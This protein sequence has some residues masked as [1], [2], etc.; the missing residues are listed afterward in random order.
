MSYIS[1]T[2][3]LEKYG[4][5]YRHHFEPANKYLRAYG[6]VARPTFW[7]MLFGKTPR[8]IQLQ[9]EHVL[10]DVVNRYG[11]ASIE[12]REHGWVPLHV[13]EPHF[14]PP[15][16]LKLGMEF[17]PG[18][19]LPIETPRKTGPKIPLK[20]GI[21]YGRA[22]LSQNLKKVRKAPSYKVPVKHKLKEDYSEYFG[23]NAIV[24]KRIRNYEAE[25]NPY[26]LKP[27]QAN[28]RVFAKLT[29]HF[30]TR[31]DIPGLEFLN[32][33]E[34]PEF[35][36]KDYIPSLP[37]YTRTGYPVPIN[38]MIAL[39]T[40]Q[41]NKLARQIREA[42]ARGLNI[43]GILEQ[44]YH[45]KWL[46]QREKFKNYWSA[47]YMKYGIIK[48]KG[49]KQTN[50]WRASD[51]FRKLVCDMYPGYKL[52]QHP[53]WINSMLYMKTGDS[54]FS[55]VNMDRIRLL[56]THDGVN[57]HT[58]FLGDP[59]P[60]NMED[61]TSDM[62]PKN[63][64]ALCDAQEDKFGNMH[65]LYK[66]F[67]EDEVVM[68]KKMRNPRN[69]EDEDEEEEE[70]EEEE[71]DEE[72]LTVD[73]FQDTRA[74]PP[75]ALPPPSPPSPQPTEEHPLILRVVPRAP[76]PDDDDALIRRAFAFARRNGRVI[77]D[78]DIFTIPDP[79]TDIPSPPSDSDDDDMKGGN[80]ALAQMYDY[81]DR[82]LPPPR[83]YF[84]FLNYFN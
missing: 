80:Y 25:T 82:Y 23:R 47:Y 56:V 3:D 27:V 83:N 37:I 24:R 9:G 2:A 68:G 79:P 28:A 1:F 71:E 50:R 39:Q 21:A 75:P 73:P 35:D 81:M 10:K 5:T 58:I 78:D 4:A 84:S 74:V 53:L 77:D 40:A 20:Y 32:I 45:E 38:S 42:R 18:L 43:E 59:I 36:L 62:N 66:P 31:K 41:E 13:E 8:Q 6:I 19:K 76:P 29:A 72:W 46:V 11:S 55:L 57:F 14:D 60:D 51:T 44:K 7:M 70:E 15:K 22:I 26:S 54:A 64:V 61:V 52:H 30:R 34:I 67:N 17:K 33:D 16:P 63:I 49:M 69:G 65:I 12:A 48:L